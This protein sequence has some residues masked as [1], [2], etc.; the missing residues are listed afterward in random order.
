MRRGV[1]RRSVLDMR[2]LG[3]TMILQIPQLPPR[4]LA[5]EPGKAPAGE[6]LEDGVEGGFST[7]V[8]FGDSWDRVIRRFTDRRCS[9]VFWRI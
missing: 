2:A 9:Y 7:L 6:A 3:S 8:A 4:N 1:L 5:A